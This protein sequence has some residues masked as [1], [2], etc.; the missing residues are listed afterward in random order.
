MSFFQAFA[1][2]LV[3][4]KNSMFPRPFSTMDENFHL[5]VNT[6]Q[7]QVVYLFAT[8]LRKPYPFHFTDCLILYQSLSL[9]YPQKAPI[10][11]ISHAELLLVLL[12]AGF[13]IDLLQ[14]MRFPENSS[15]V[16]PR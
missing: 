7:I 10:M 13:V 8:N 12:A 3:L 11:W 14:L 16:P 6:G 2:T 5:D 15:W 4:L 1:I 9:N